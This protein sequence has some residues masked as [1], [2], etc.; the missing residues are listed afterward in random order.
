MIYS[1]NLILL[2]IIIL[3]HSK[4][5]FN[6]AILL[7]YFSEKQGLNHLVRTLKEAGREGERDRE[8]ERERDHIC[9]IFTEL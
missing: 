4:E 1:S 9:D 2:H 3:T 6:L 5:T 7:I 8:R